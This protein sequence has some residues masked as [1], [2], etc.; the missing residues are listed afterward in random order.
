MKKNFQ[1][2]VIIIII[3]AI[4][5]CCGDEKESNNIPWAAVRFTVNLE[6]VDNTL[7]NH[8]ATKIFTRDN[9]TIAN[10]EVGFSGLLVVSGIE[11][12]TRTGNPVL[13]VFDLCCPNECRKDIVVVPKGLEAGCPS[14]NSVFDLTYGFGN[15]TDGPAKYRKLSLKRYKAIPELPY[16]GKYN[17]SRND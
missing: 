12:D 11:V 14:C 13:Y 15:A 7:K 5:S 1:Y 17:I 16:N 6:S 9:V 2:K 3:S 8:A 4:F 10:Q